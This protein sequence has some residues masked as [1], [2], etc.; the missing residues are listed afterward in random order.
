MWFKVEYWAANVWSLLSKMYE[1]CVLTLCKFVCWYLLFIVN[2][3]CRGWDIWRIKLGVE[4]KSDMYEV[5]HLPLCCL[6]LSTL[7]GVCGSFFI[8]LFSRL[9]ATVMEV[10]L[11][12]TKQY[13]SLNENLRWLWRNDDVQGLVDCNRNRL[14]HNFVFFLLPQENGL[15]LYPFINSGK[16][17]TWRTISSI[18]CLFGSSTCFEQLCAHPQEDNCINTTSGII[19]LC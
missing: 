15:Q 7:F 3:Y 4:L 16:W 18:I 1:A 2:C 9:S 19:T 12:V 6:F 5:N 14:C 17:P 10:P 13:S 8:V 11:M